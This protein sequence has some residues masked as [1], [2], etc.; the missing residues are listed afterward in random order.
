MI[1][2]CVCMFIYV[3]LLGICLIVLLPVTLY[4]VLSCVYTCMCDGGSW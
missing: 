3:R 1:Q 2:A 4:F